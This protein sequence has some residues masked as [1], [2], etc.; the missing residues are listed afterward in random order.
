MH[1][2]ILQ[3]TRDGIAYLRIERGDMVGHSDFGKKARMITAMAASKCELLILTKEEIGVM[4]ERFPA[5]HEDMISRGT[6]TLR[7]E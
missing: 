1:G 5:I 7:K 6:E 3:I 2:I 4:K